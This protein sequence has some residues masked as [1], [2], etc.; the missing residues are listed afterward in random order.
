MVTKYYTFKKTLFYI[1]R[2]YYKNE[3]NKHEI[4]IG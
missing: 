2:V 3:I 4:I 1:V